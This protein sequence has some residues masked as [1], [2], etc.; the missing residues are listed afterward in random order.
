MRPGIDGPE[1]RRH[2][3][4]RRRVRVAGGDDDLTVLP[5]C[6]EAHDPVGR[7]LRDR[8]RLRR[9]QHHRNRRDL[10]FFKLGGRAVLEDQ[11]HRHAGMPEEPGRVERRERLDLNIDPGKGLGERFQ[12]R[13]D[14]R[15]RQPQVHPHVKGP[16]L[17]VCERGRVA[18]EVAV[19]LQHQLRAGEELPA[20][21]GDL[22]GPAA[23][24]EGVAEE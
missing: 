7:G 13:R 3:E 20:A 6:F 11:R 18:R 24:K 14:H 15:G 10:G 22:Q 21:L 2:D 12:V 8:V 4:G 17:R 9:D 16:R 5:Q 19:V 23:V 1:A